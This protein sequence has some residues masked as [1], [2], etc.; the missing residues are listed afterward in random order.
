MRDN[1]YSKCADEDDEG[2]SKFVRKK[3]NRYFVGGFFKSVN[4]HVI[5]KYV[6]RRGIKVTLVTIFRPRQLD[7]DHSR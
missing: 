1:E 5:T 3:T 6:K 7:G 2:F 4:D